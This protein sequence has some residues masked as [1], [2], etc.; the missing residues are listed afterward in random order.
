VQVQAAAG[1]AVAQMLAPRLDGALGLHVRLKQILDLTPGVW[2]AA[3]DGV[4]HL[5]SDS[6]NEDALQESFTYHPSSMSVRGMNCVWGM[7]IRLGQIPSD[8]ALTWAW[9]L[10]GAIAQAISLVAAE[11]GAFSRP[12]KA[13]NGSA[14][15]AALG[16]DTAETAAYALLIGRAS[17]R[18]PLVDLA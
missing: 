3:S 2:R 14:L 1:R 6:W 11:D 12:Y 8:A 7:T 9:A 15:G 18:S 16:A 10:C 13:F 17:F 5:V 4:L